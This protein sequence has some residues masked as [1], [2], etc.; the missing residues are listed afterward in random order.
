MEV[1]TLLIQLGRKTGDGLPKGATGAALTAYSESL[2]IAR[3]LVE[4]DP[5]NARWQRDQLVAYKGVSDAGG[6]AE[7]TLQLALKAADEMK[8]LGVLAQSDEPIVD[9]LRQRLDTLDR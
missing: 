5:L 3:R 8:E 1:Y 2:A 4:A 9:A 6:D 7:Q